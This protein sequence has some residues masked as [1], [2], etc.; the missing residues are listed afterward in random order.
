MDQRKSLALCLLCAKDYAREET[1]SPHGWD[2]A[3]ATTNNN[4]SPKVQLMFSG[5]HFFTTDQKH[6]RL[7][8]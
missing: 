1:V 2:G 4:N 8:N 3:G 5:K 7:I 6:R